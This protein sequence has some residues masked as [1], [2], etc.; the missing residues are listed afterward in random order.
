MDTTALGQTLRQRRETLRREITAALAQL[1]ENRQ[2][3]TF[4][5][6]HDAKDDAGESMAGLVRDAELERDLHE[7]RRIDAALLRLAEGSYGICV[8]CGSEIAPARLAAEPASARCLS[9]ESRVEQRQR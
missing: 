9:C 8:D 5:E 3:Q 2:A 1:R 4:E 6:V 7:A